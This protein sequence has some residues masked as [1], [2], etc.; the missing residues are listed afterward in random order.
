MAA[1]AGRAAINSVARTLQ[2]GLKVNMLSWTC[3]IFD[4]CPSLGLF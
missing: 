1:K 2:L 3:A 4:I